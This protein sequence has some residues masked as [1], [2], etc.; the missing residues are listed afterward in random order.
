M[1]TV[2]TRFPVSWCREQFPA[3]ARPFDGR[4]PEALRCRQRREGLSGHDR[5]VAHRQEGLAL[6]RQG[7][8]KEPAALALILQEGHDRR[9]SVGRRSEWNAR[10]GDDGLG[11]HRLRFRGQASGRLAPADPDTVEIDAEP[12]NG[13]VVSR[14]KRL[15]G[16]DAIELRQRA[17]IDEESTVELTG[18]LGPP[19]FDLE[20]GVRIDPGGI[21]CF[22]DSASMTDTVFYPDALRYQ[23]DSSSFSGNFPCFDAFFP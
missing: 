16:V 7:R 21:Y 12:R 13:A 2:T 23:R 9:G 20:Q 6:V 17:V 4:E 3:L 15:G 19:N 11:R 14:C 5:G 1:T 22:Q 18:T 10:Y 8:R